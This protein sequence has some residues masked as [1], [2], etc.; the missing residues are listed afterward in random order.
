MDRIFPPF[1][2]CLLPLFSS[3]SDDG[4]SG[5]QHNDPS[6]P[7][8]AS[9]GV[10]PSTPVDSSSTEPA[11]ESEVLARIDGTSIPAGDR[12]EAPT[13]VADVWRT[14][15]TRV[16]SRSSDPS[17][18]HPSPEDLSPEDGIHRDRMNG[19]SNHGDSSQANLGHR[20]VRSGDGVPLSPRVDATVPQIGLWRVRVGAD[21]AE[22][23]NPSEDAIARVRT[24]AD[25]L[26]PL[27]QPHAKGRR[28]DS[29][30][31]SLVLLATMTIMLLS[32]RFIVPPVVEEIRY[33]WHRGSLR[34]E[35]EESKGG[36]E[37]V[38]LV[39][40]SQAYQMVTSRVGPSV[41]HIDVT[42]LDLERQ[43]S[44]LRTMLQTDG[45]PSADQGSGVVVDGAGYVLTNHHVVAGGREIF[46]TLSDGRRRPAAIVGTDPL[47]D[48]AVLKVD[49]DGLLPIQ[50]GD[51]DQCRVGSP[52]WAVGS[53][54]GLDRTVTF[55]ILSGK[56]RMVRANT[57]YQDFMQ[58]DVAV[59][60]G[61]SGGPLV[62]ASGSL[63][64]INTAIVGETYQ[65]VSF[66]IPSNVAK[67]V[68]EQ[69]REVGKVQRAWLGVMLAEVPDEMLFDDNMRVRG[70]LV[71]DLPLN[72]ENDFASPAFD[73]GIRP[74]DLIRRIDEEMVRDQAHLMQ[75]IGRS[76][77]GTEVN[78]EVI[79]DGQSKMLSIR[80]G[81]RPARLD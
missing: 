34:A 15:E 9:G 72:A 24:S 20:D 3:R 67:Q 59:N 37:G 62:D 80:L 56:H 32:A 33:A 16:R 60:P 77:A 76:I 71:R 12:H 68:Y 78:V 35:Y 44:A 43:P 63:V 70:A 53:P 4:R 54:F 40:L 29:L 21:A 10:P 74:G 5:D 2:I 75:I 41:V 55:G 27:N 30:T 28:Q 1:W 65:G 57:Q 11:Q 31:Q 58:S 47:T 50:W 79:R 25:T 49:A 42:R 36:L 17:T 23:V 6:D 46:V 66:S 51:S 81:R 18:G 8:A 64:G 39:A 19:D 52:V 61:N 26:Q 38:Q 13:A 22:V 45:V 69:I 48:L 7:V 73:G 14:D